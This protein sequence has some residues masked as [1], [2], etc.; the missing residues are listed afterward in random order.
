MDGDA[1]TLD[2]IEVL[3]AMAPETRRALAGRCRWHH[4]MSGQQ[5]VAHLD[6]TRD[7]FF[8]AEGR[9]RATS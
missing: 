4:Y 3:Q 9:V 6:T 2:R 5:I 8:I 7:V 1:E